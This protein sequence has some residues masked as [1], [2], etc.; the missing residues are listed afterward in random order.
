MSVS[1]YMPNEIY[2]STNSIVR[3]SSLLGYT[4]NIFT[5][6]YKYQDSSVWNLKQYL[7]VEGSENNTFDLYDIKKYFKIGDNPI[8]YFKPIDYKIDVEFFYTDIHSGNTLTG[9]ET[10]DQCMVMF[11]PK[12]VIGFAKVKEDD[13]YGFLSSDDYNFGDESESTPLTERDWDFDNDIQDERFD[14]EHNLDFN[15]ESL[16]EHDKAHPVFLDEDGSI[17]GR[18]AIRVRIKAD[19]GNLHTGSIPIVGSDSP[20]ATN[21]KINHEGF[22]S[23]ANFDADFHYYAPRTYG[24]GYMAHYYQ[25]YQDIYY[26]QY[27]IRYSRETL[28]GYNAVYNHYQYYNTL[29]AYSYYGNY[30]V[31]DKYTGPHEEQMNV[32]VFVNGINYYTYNNAKIL[33][34]D[35]YYTNT[36]VR[37]LQVYSVA[38][39]IP[40]YNYVPLRY[41]SDGYFSVYANYVENFTIEPHDIYRYYSNEN[42]YYY[43]YGY[44]DILYSYIEPKTYTYGE[45]HRTGYGDLPTLYSELDHYYTIHYTYTYGG[46][47]E[48]SSS[49]TPFNG[50]YYYYTMTYNTYPV[51]DY[52]NYNASYYYYKSNI[53]YTPNYN[54]GA[55]YKYYTYNVSAYQQQGYNYAFVN[56]Y[57]YNLYNGSATGSYPYS[58]T[59]PTGSYYITGYDMYVGAYGQYYGYKGPFDYT[60]SQPVAY[61]KYSYYTATYYISYRYSYDARHD[62]SYSAKVT[63]YRY[64]Y[65]AAYRY[66]NGYYMDIG[67]STYSYSAAR[68]G[69]KYST[70]RYYTYYTYYSYN[71]SFYYARARYEYRSDKYSYISGYSYRTETYTYYTYRYATNYS[72]Y[73]YRESRLD[74]YYYK[75][76]YFPASYYYK[77]SY[78]YAYN[79]V[80]YNLYGYYTYYATAGGTAYYP[81]YYYIADGPH[82]TYAYAYQDTSFVYNVPT[83]GT[84]INSYYTYITSY[85]TGYREDVAYQS[86]YKYDKTYH[87]SNY[88]STIYHN[89]Q[90]EYVYYT[91]DHFLYIYD[92]YS[93]SIYNNTTRTDFY[94]YG[95][96]Y[97]FG[98]YTYDYTYYTY[99]N[100]Y[101]PGYGYDR[102]KYNGVIPYTYNYRYHEVVGYYTITGDTRITSGYIVPKYTGAYYTLMNNVV[103]EPIEELYTSTLT[104][105]PIYIFY[106]YGSST[107]FNY[108]DYA[109]NYSDKHNYYSYAGIEYY[110]SSYSS[111][112]DY[113]YNALI[114]YKDDLEYYYSYIT[115]YFDHNMGQDSFPVYNYTAP[116]GHIE[117]YFYSGKNTKA[118]MYFYQ[119]YYYTGYLYSSYMYQNF[120]FNYY[121]KPFIFY[122][123]KAYKYEGG[124]AVTQEAKYEYFPQS[125]YTYQYISKYLGVYVYDNKAYKRLNGSYNN[126]S[127]IGYYYTNKTYYY[128]AIGYYS[129]RDV[130]VNEF[131]ASA[132][133]IYTVYKYVNDGA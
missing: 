91:T 88:Y 129:R 75:I 101:G 65:T 26:D 72:A 74:N 133:K 23:V 54:Y 116:I 124:I 95:Y 102:L 29:P 126:N 21:V 117:E 100:S 27:Y 49:F 50:Y 34:Y 69:Y 94:K 64:A 106:T 20:L 17:V 87:K 31:K 30:D 115:G 55:T 130:P 92:T 3:W 33:N 119:G 13:Y 123:N 113:Y 15:L 63:R 19:D 47:Y 84:T 51:Y 83:Q 98:T 41:Q 80:T 38:D 99:A 109:V 118:Y 128:P 16:N 46:R 28:Y 68:R 121:N 25:T 78:I 125:N 107:G 61:P 52:Y 66:Q 37:Q 53:Y 122:V 14:D 36:P 40:K 93:Y 90:F 104:N 89:N 35:T 39:S 112:L 42:G 48:Y 111:R 8:K 70:R 44:N 2:L 6:Y 86:L 32:T 97:Y 82:P 60:Y 45:N 58:Y 18:D 132:P 4:F 12:S 127:V 114:G 77:T 110:I 105:Y 85:N 79:V 56:A 43:Y 22:K 108:Y 67:Y 103:Y 11:R 24:T 73:S 131:I 120:K 1:F 59:Y 96:K 81:Y 71:I 5:V 10:S 62:Y 9:H 76:Q 57:Y 7:P